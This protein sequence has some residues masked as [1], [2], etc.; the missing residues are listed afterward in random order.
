MP[1]LSKAMEWWWLGLLATF[2][3]Q[4]E[5]EL[6]NTC[7][8]GKHHKKKPGPENEL[9]EQCSPWK[10][11]ACCT[12]NT[13]WDTHLDVSLLYNFNFGHC[14]V[15]TPSCR[16]HFI[17]VACLYECSP[18]LG[19]WIQKVSSRLGKESVLNVP[20]CWED[21]T[22]WWEDCRNSYT[23]TSD[24]YSGW[25]WST[26]QSHC[27]SLSSC[28][29][30]PHYFPSPADLCEKIW[31]NSYKATKEHRGKGHCIQMWFDP[32]QGNPNVAVAHFYASRAISLQ[33]PHIMFLVSLLP[34]A[35]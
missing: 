24:W 10:D 8:E 5:R 16:R 2:V 12:H 27:P 4:A 3:V 9:H 32:A 7:M 33:L 6:L 1:V 25:D 26:G 17:Q 14:G 15:M 21:C 31:R 34:F 28:R 13:S 30:F 18:N 35:L 19:P 22:E 20:L 23:C 11:N 29:P